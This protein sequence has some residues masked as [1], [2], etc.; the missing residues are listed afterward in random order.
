MKKKN[1]PLLM[2]RLAAIFVAWGL[3]L[4]G[5]CY[6]LTLPD[7]IEVIEEDAFEGADAL[8]VVEIPE[9]VREIGSHAFDGCD[10]IEEIYVLNKNVTLGDQALGI[11][12]EIILHAPA[13]SMVQMYAATY[14]MSFVYVVPLYEPL[15]EYAA[16]QLN[17]SYSTH[18]C[19]TYVREC[20]LNALGIKIYATCRDVEQ[21]TNGKRISEISDL[22]PGDIICWKNDEVSYCTHVGMYVG[23]GTV[24]GR[25]YDS[26]V[27]IESSRSAG[28]V[29]YNYIGQS[30]YTRNFMGAWRII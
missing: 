4:S 7:C 27:F 20:Y 23:E 5:S 9:S 12:K 13:G 19:V 17:T 11:R 24:G 16:T 21:K 25:H 29:R 22:A 1:F 8:T 10:G 26:G 28:K 15:L 30:Y 18:D 14:D 6:A 2:R 3:L